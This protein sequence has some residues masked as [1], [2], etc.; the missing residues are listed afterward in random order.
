MRIGIGIL[1]DELESEE[2]QQKHVV[3]LISS[4]LKLSEM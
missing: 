2:F 1:P 4:S 3:Y